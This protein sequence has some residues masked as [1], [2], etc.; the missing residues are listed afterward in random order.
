MMSRYSPFVARLLFPSI[1]VRGPASAALA[2]NGNCLYLACHKARGESSQ[3][4]RAALCVLQTGQ[5]KA[6]QAQLATSGRLWLG[7]HQTLL[8][9][10][11]DMLCNA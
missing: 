9:C 8:L 3:D 4:E 10:K 11:D 7:E 6:G 1:A 2:E 5:K